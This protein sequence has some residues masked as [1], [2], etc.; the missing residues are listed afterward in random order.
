M[1]VYTYVCMYVF[2]Y[3]HTPTHPPT[4]KNSRV[5]SYAARWRTRAYCAAEWWKQI[6]GRKTRRRCTQERTAA[7][8]AV[9]SKV[10]THTHTHTH[11]Q[12]N[13]HPACRRGLLGRLLWKARS[14]CVCVCVCVCTCIMSLCMF[15]CVCTGPCDWCGTGFC[16]RSGWG[17]K[18][19]GCDGTIG[20][21]G[22]G[23]M[24]VLHTRT[25]DTHTHMHAC[26]QGMEFVPN[27]LSLSRARARRSLSRACCVSLAGARQR[28]MPGTQSAKTWGRPL[29]LPTLMAL[30]P[31]RLI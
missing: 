21:P 17:D 9:E 1:Y 15:V 26:M 11:K 4:H 8:N 10:H 3:A 18:S 6:S 27:E 30:G 13:M 16:C 31:G 7:T 14:M 12:T 22:K 24:Y 2:L 25:H 28:R 23:H 29:R 5:K 20:V 19:G